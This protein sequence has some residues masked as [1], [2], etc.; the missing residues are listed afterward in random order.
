MA[1]VAVATAALWLLVTYGGPAAKATVVP[2]PYRADFANGVSLLG[3]RLPAAPACAGERVDLALDFFTSATPPADKKF[4]VHVTTADDS[5]KVAQADTLPADGYNPMTRW[6]AG[7]LVPQSVAI[8]IDAAVAPGSYK[9]VFGMYDPM[10]GENVPVLSSPDTLPGD[11]LRLG[12]LTI[13]ACT[14]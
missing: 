12:D 9:V 11:R 13:A 1:I 5:A 3:Y 7:E 10:T 4:F 14:P 6:E 8:D 2:T